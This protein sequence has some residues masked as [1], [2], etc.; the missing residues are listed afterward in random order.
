[1]SSDMA[2][3]LEFLLNPATKSLQR[4]TWSPAVDIYRLKDGWLLKFDLAGVRPEDIELHASGRN[5]T[6]RGRRRDWVVEERIGCS[7]YSME[8]NYSHFER[9][10]ELPCDVE[11]IGI[12]SEYRDG[13]LLLRLDTAGCHQ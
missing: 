7:L 5:L 4:A 13:M 12:Q 1:M 9:T 11:N 2:R 3:M 6:V 10:L 8:I